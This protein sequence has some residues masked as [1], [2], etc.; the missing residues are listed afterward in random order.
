MTA[1]IYRACYLF[2]VLLEMILMLYVIILW[3]PVSQR[4]R[5]YMNDI[6]A[7]ILEPIRFLLRHSSF[8]S[9]LMDFSPLIGF[10]LISYL[11]KFFFIR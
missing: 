2:F 8:F 11:Q 3:L 5:K 6:V 10:V 7:P 9:P 1:I 4:L